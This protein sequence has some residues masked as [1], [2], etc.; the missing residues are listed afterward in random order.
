[1]GGAQGVVFVVVAL[2]TLAPLAQLVVHV[3]RHGGVL[4]GAY[5]ADAYDQ[6][7]YLAWIRD[8]GSHLLASNL[9]SI[10]PTPHDYLQPMF[11]LSGLLWRLGA[12]VQLAYLIWTPVGL[13]VLF[14]GCAVYARRLLPA[15][16][17]APAAAVLLAVFYETP[18]VA[19]AHWTS[20]LSPF[21]QFQLLL[22]SD[23]AN[24]ALQLWGFAHT[25]ITIGLMPV[26]LLAVERL[27]TA[28]AQGAL[29]WSTVAAVAGALVSWLR[30]WQGLILLVIVALLFVARP[31][32]RRF[33]V[34]VLP[35]CATVL[36]LVYGVVL[37]R[38]DPSWASFQH[39]T[40]TTGTAPW[41]A[42]LASFGPLGALAALG[43]R[44][45][46]DDGQAMLLLWPLACA[47]VYFLV[48]EFPPHALSGITVPLAVL[49]VQGFTRLRLPRTL[50]LPAAVAALAAVTVPTAVYHAQTFRDTFTTPSDAPAL[51][52]QVIS[53]DQAAALRL[54]AHSPR[55][56]GVLAPQYLAMAVPG[57]TGRATFA[58]HLMWQPSA[59]NE[60]AGQFYAPTLADPTGALRRAILVRSGAV[61]VIADCAAPRSLSR[62]ITPLARPVRRFGCVTVFERRRAG[63]SAAA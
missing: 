25:A 47:A 54:I 27:L 5:G 1:M 2:W 24:P 8:E 30:P 20:V 15:G 10:A 35:V 44:V 42:L 36:P 61:F 29:A 14:V 22:A 56:G 58:G 49:A 16:W 37:A 32:R 41:W 17:G 43:F 3:A 12:S 53:A 46:R 51:E 4:T 63:G 26:F 39:K 45:P 7:A 6:L 19:V 21:H 59:N 62:A 11:F 60:L 52:L 33:L 31:P 34:L 23:D 50:A 48:P 13:L 28:R 18:V 38:A 40:L 9:Y 55:A 57:L